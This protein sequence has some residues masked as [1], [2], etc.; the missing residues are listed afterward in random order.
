MENNVAYVIE[1]TTRSVDFIDY[2]GEYVLYAMVKVNLGGYSKNFICTGDL[3][4]CEKIKQS[5]T[6]RE[7]WG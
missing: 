5:L 4:Y 3:E 7:L 1:K 6:N 2:E